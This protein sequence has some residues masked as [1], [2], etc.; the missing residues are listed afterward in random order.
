MVKQ[1]ETMPGAGRSIFHVAMRIIG[2]CMVVLA[3]SLQGAETE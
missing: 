2:P 1:L 3:Y